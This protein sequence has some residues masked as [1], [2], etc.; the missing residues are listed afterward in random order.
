MAPVTPTSWCSRPWNSPLR[1]RWAGDLLLT[2]NTTKVMRRHLRLCY[3]RLSCEDVTLSEISQSQTPVRPHFYEFT[4]TESG[5]RPPGAG[6]GER[7]RVSVSQTRSAVGTAVRW[8][9]SP[10][11]VSAAGTTEGARKNSRGDTFYAAG[12]LPR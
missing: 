9:H 11:T 3:E 2:D 7:G 5:G 6:G 10:G 12:V 4:E 1:G 8:L